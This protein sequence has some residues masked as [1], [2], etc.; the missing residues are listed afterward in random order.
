M[1]TNLF[2]IFDP[3][4]NSIRTLNWIR[5]LYF[6]IFLPNLYWI[7]PSKYNYLWN[8]I[9]IN[10]SKEIK[11]S[12][13]KLNNYFN[14]LILNSL[15]IL[16][17][18]NNFIRLF[19]YI[20]N[21]TRHLSISISLSLTIWIR[22][23]IFGWT[24]NSYNI[25]IHL[26][27]QGTPFILIPFIVIIERVRNLIRP[28]TLAIRLRA[29]IIAGHLLITLI[30]Q[31]ITNL[32]LNLIIIIILIQSI[33]VILELAVSFIQAYIFSILRSLYLIETN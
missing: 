28:L 31:T 11:N 17:L 5:I 19:P 30:R 20:F 12:L 9:L 22:F 3:S 18:L 4:T 21:T 6:I 27:P 2:S 16:I 24:K 7:T 1:I 32:N 15:F 8:F 23:I 25:F 26:T 13:N 14:I 29:N 33:L 10:L